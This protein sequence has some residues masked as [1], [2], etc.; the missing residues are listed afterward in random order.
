MCCSVIYKSHPTATFLPAWEQLNKQHGTHT[1]EI[2]A[3]IKIL[4]SQV[5]ELMLIILAPRG[6]DGGGTV[7][8][9]RTTK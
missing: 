4:T 8:S 6:W 7:V 9:A 3:A 1:M 2:F 5:W